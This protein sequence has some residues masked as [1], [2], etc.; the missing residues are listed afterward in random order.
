MLENNLDTPNTESGIT[1]PEEISNDS[2]NADKEATPK[3]R[4]RPVSSKS[5]ETA[6][7]VTV[8]Q[9]ASVVTTEEASLK[10]KPL[11]TKA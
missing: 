10:L 11:K 7:T 1:A 6:E 5:K 4:K 9:T 8:E 3:R 2:A